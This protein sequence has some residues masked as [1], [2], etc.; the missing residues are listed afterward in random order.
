MGCSRPCSRRA[1]G[2][3][4][5]R[6][7]H[8]PSSPRSSVAE[9]DRDPGVDRSELV[10]LLRRLG[11]R[12]LGTFALLDPEDVASRFGADAVLCH[13]LARG[14]DPRPPARRHPPEELTVEIELDPP[15]DRVDAAAFAA[16]GLAERLHRTLAG[17]GLSCTRLGVAAHTVSGEQ[18]HRVWRCAEPLTPAGT[19]DRV[20]WQLDA[21]LTRRRTTAA[22]DQGP[23]DQGPA[24]QG[25]A[26]RGPADQES[27]RRRPRR[28]VAAVADSRGDGHRGRA[29]ARSVGRGRG[30]RR[31][32]GSGAGPGAGAAGAGVGG[33]RGA[34]RGPGSGGAGAAGALGRR[35]RGRR[36]PAPAGAGRGWIG[37]IRADA[38]AAD[39]RAET[40]SPLGLPI[41]GGPAS[42]DAD[43]E[44]ERAMAPLDDA[45]RIA[46]A[47]WPPDVVRQT[48]RIS[49]LDAPVVRAADTTSVA[50][51]REPAG[52][53]AAEPAPPRPTNRRRRPPAR[54]STPTPTGPEPPPPWPGRLPAPSPATVPPEPLPAELVDTA[55]RPIWL[56]APEQLSGPPHLLAVDG[57][58]PQDV[59][60]WAGPWPVRQRWWSPD[61][62]TE[63][64]AAA[65]LPGRGGVPAGRPRGEVVGHRELRLTGGGMPLAPAWLSAA[66]A[67]CRRKAVGRADRDLLRRR[68]PLV[69][70]RQAPPGAGAGR[71]PARRSGDDHVPQL[72]ARPDRP[73]AVRAE[74]R[75]VPRGQVRPD[76]G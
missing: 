33:H 16:R 63:Q 74:P 36:G 5:R 15:V 59:E 55:G 22:A 20:R 31:A 17:H 57:A 70:H 40:V 47:G 19:V 2:W 39:P 11:L 12:S 61:G 6:G 46:P 14:L 32:G 51:T 64:P 75:A 21:W 9:L 68:V 58:A 13:R 3:P 43:P 44:L 56:T 50:P 71:V 66:T 76:P 37:R 25:P 10:G 4:W 65:A 73:R 24:D 35:A 28:G 26:D 49:A 69:L 23:A 54:R 38:A 72:P 29:A 41:P 27:G 8:R 34:H 18:L 67:R 62:V 42:P 52:Q 48:G 45:D 60:G 7:T 30:G 53:P 1:G